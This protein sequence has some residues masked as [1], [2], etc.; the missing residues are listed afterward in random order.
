MQKLRSLFGWFLK[1]SLIKK[2][3][4]I[5]IIIGAG[6]L[7]VSRISGQEQA[8]PQ[9]QTATAERGT[10]ISSV[11]ASG[12][13]SSGSSASITTSATGVVNEVL[14]S[15][16]DIVKQGDKIA[17]LVLDQSALQK[18]TAS[19]ANYLSAQNTLNA[20]KSKMDS[21]QA[22]LFTANQ[23]FVKG[24]GT[25][26]PVKDDPTYIIQRANWLQ[27]EANYTQQENVIRQAEV[28]LSSAW[29]SYSLTSGTITAPISGKISNLTL[30][31]GLSITS[32]STSTSNS[33]GSN[34]NSTST[35]STNNSSQSYGNIE[36][37]GGQ[38]QAVVNLTEID[39]TKVAVGQKVTIT[40]DAFPDKTFTG[41]V[42]TIN[43]NG[44]V[45]SGV[46]TYPTTIVFDSAINYIYPNMGVNANI[47][48]NIKNDVIIVPSGAV[49]TS[50]GE[51]T[52][53]VLK[54]DQ[55]TSVSVEV[56]K[57]NDTQTEIVSGINE[58]DTVVTGTISTGTSSQ[59]QSGSSP[60]GGFGGGNAG[61]G[62]AVMFRRN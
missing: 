42:A 54:N 36:L 39:V 6:W 62:G 43:T 45:S 59:S 25:S 32:G 16:G 40:M 44:S 31:P 23:T 46:T 50:N 56:G 26:D 60:F 2:I 7:I 55:I 29:L 51:N 1:V 28:S 61:R 19:W 8:K 9:Y 20:A 41:R 49:Q 35:S 38:V 17:T 5:A 48:T 34:S 3:L 47:I 37:E 24:A 15:N 57:S 14:V 53:R 18:Q 10:L 22:D 11:T 52:V 12:T 4:I 33:T 30:T 21:L 58:G 13:I 27:A